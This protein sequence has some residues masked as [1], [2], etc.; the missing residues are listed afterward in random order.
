M[1][2]VRYEDHPVYG[3]YLYDHM[4]FRDLDD[5]TVLVL[6]RLQHFRLTERNFRLSQGPQEGQIERFWDYSSCA[7]ATHMLD[8]WDGQGE[9]APDVV[10]VTPRR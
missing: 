10:I 3:L 8:T 7:I 5:G 9:P 1:G 4:G 2:G 6:T